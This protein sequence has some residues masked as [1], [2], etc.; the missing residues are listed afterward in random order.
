MSPQTGVKFD[1]LSPRVENALYK[2]IV[3]N[4]MAMSPQCIANTIH[5]LSNQRARWARLPLYVRVALTDAL[6][7][8]VKK[9]GEQ[10]VTNCISGLGRLG[11]EW[12]ELTQQQRRLLGDAFLRL[13]PDLGTK[14]LA[15]SVHGLGRMNADFQVG[16][17]GPRGTDDGD[18]SECQV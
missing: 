4:H 15:M 7:R 13:L 18:V 6:E 1:A 11:A 8:S 2:A 16:F 14:G 9:F 12:A 10:D 3:R 5:G 17:T